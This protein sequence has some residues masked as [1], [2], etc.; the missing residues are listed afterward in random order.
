MA[1][2][3]VMKPVKAKVVH[4]EGLYLAVMN[5]QDGLC[6]IRAKNSYEAERKMSIVFRHEI[7]GKTIDFNANDFPDW[8]KPDVPTQEGGT[9]S[10]G[11]TP[12]EAR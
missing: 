11:E 8:D 7:K 2:N 5:H 10:G 1:L 9:T 12:S 6:Y 3:I 4:G